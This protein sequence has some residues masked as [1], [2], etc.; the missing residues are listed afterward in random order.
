MAQNWTIIPRSKE[1]EIVED[2]VVNS[3]TQ[4]LWLNIQ[5]KEKQTIGTIKVEVLAVPAQ[6]A[7]VQ[8]FMHSHVDQLNFRFDMQI[9]GPQHSRSLTFVCVFHHVVRKRHY[10]ADSKI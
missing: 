3:L 9:R 2:N 4:T 5:I 1:L 10:C 7:T 8:N 6:Q